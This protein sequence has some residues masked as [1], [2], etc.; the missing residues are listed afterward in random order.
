MQAFHPRYVVDEQGVPRGVVLEIAEFRN[1]LRSAGLQV[2]D[3]PAPESL[4]LSDLGWTGEETL[5]TRVRLRSF[6]EDWEAP[7]MDAYDRL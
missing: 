7:G 1:L 4:P 6:A 2:P 5:E 3:T